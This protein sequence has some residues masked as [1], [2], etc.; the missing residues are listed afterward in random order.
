M[1]RRAV[2]GHLELA[3][4]DRCRGGAPHVASRVAPSEP[5]HACP[6]A[7]PRA[8]PR[9]CPRASPTASPSAHA[10]SLHGPCP[11]GFLA[12]F[13]GIGPRVGWITIG[14]YVFFGAYE[15]SM[16]MLWRSGVWG[17]KPKYSAK[18]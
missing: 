7:R 10:P 6:R 2:R 17:E 1:P 5:A 18:S 11:Q 3:P 13:K 8:R 16:E 15:K 9:A 4:H 12:L 14:G